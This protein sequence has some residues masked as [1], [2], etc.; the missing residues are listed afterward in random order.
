MTTN[1]STNWSYGLKFVQLMKNR[2]FHDGIKQTPYEALFG[3]KMRLDL[4]TSSLPGDLINSME[5]EEQLS[6]LVSSADIVE[7]VLK[8]LKVSR[9]LNEN[10]EVEILEISN[11]DTQE[12]DIFDINEFPI[13]LEN[14]NAELEEDMQLTSTGEESVEI[15]EQLEQRKSQIHDNREAALLN[16]QVQAEKMK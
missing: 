7:P 2:A 14:I 1:N 16:L 8:K 13:Y 6:E 10:A 4:K 5:S 11:Y 12:N 9:E 15:R 3:V